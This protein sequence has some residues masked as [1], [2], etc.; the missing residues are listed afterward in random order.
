MRLLRFVLLLSLVS[1][2]ACGGDEAED[3]AG[4]ADAAADSG[5]G[6]VSTDPGADATDD[7]ADLPDTGVDSDAGLPD[8]GED[9]DAGV[10]DTGVDS[11]AGVPDTGVDADAGVPDVGADTDGGGFDAD[12]GNDADTTVPDGGFDADTSVPDGGVDADGGFDADTGVDTGVDTG[13]DTDAGGT[14]D[15]AR[16]CRDLPAAADGVCDVTPGSGA[17]L[18]RGNVLAPD[19][20]LEGG[21]VLLSASGTI[22]CVG[23]DCGAEPEA[24]GATVVTCGDGVIS[25]GLIN[26]H[27]HITF[28][29]NSPGEWGAERF[30]HR[31]DW[32]RGIRGH[33]RVPAAGFAS[34]EEMAWGELRQVM[35][36]TTSLAGSGTGRGFLRNVDG[37][38]SARLGV[39]ADVDYE[40]FPLGDSGGEL[41]SS[42]CGYPELPP[43]SVLGA[44][45][46]LPH[47]SEGIDP[48]ARNEFLCLSSDL[49]GGVDITEPNSAFVHG[50]GLTAID[51]DELALNDT[52][53]IWSPRSNISLYGVTAPVT[54]YA[55]QGVRIG[56]GTDWTPSGSMNMQR[57]LACASYL[58]EV[59]YGGWFSDR[60]LWAMA[61]S[62]NAD[63]LG[64]ADQVGYLRPG[65]FGDIAIYDGAAALSPF[66]AVI[67]ASVADV[68]LVLRAGV[69]MYGDAD[70]TSLFD[71]S[72]AC[73]PMPE[74]VCG[75]SKFV[76]AERESTFDFATLIAENVG[77]YDLFFC[78]EP[79][80]EPT[81]IPSRPGEFA[82]PTA[83][84]MD[85]DGVVDADDLCPMV[86]D[87][88]R[89][90]DD[91]AQADA[92]VDGIG[93]ACDPCPLDADTDECSPP[94][95][96]D[97]DRDGIINADDNCPVVP[98]ED[99]SD[100]DGDLIGDVCDACPDDANPGGS[101][102]PASIY[103]VKT[104]VVAVGSSVAVS[105]VVTAVAD[106]GFFVQVPTEAWDGELAASFSG[107][108][109]YDPSDPDVVLGAP[110]RVTG[111]VNDFFGQIQLSGSLVQP[112]DEDWTLP[113]P[114]P[115]S[116]AD[117]ATDGAV[118]DAYEAVLVSVGEVTVT[119][120][121]LPSGG[122]DS[123]PN[124]EFEVDGSLRVNDFLY[125]IDPAP[126][127]GDV[128]DL[129]GV[130][131]FA[132][133]D[134]KLEPRDGSDV[135]FVGF[136]DPTIV[137]AGPF[138]VYF[139]AGTTGPSVGRTA[140][141]TLLRP[142]PAGLTASV[143]DSEGV[144]VPGTITFEE[145]ELTTDIVL[146]TTAV[147]ATTL[148]TVTVSL[149]GFDSS[150]DVDVLVWDVDG[151]REVVSVSPPELT[152]SFGTSGTIIAYLDGPAGEGVTVAV[153]PDPFEA[154]ASAPTLV[155][156]PVNATSVDIVLVAGET[157]ATAT[158]TV[159][160]EAGSP[161]S[162]TVQ[163]IEEEPART[164]EPGD[165]Y[166]SEI[167]VRSRAGS[168][169]TGEWFEVRNVSAAPLVLDDCEL[170]D[171]GSHAIAASLTVDPG[172]YLVFGASTENGLA[173]DY[174]YD[175][176][177]L[178]NG[179]ETLGI[180]CGGVVIDDFDYPGSLVTLGAS[181]Q[182]VAD[183]LTPET[184][185]DNDNWCVAP[186]D[187]TYGGTALRGTPG[188]ENRCE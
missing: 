49:S 43:L 163:I 98:N 55:S 83:D 177:A 18:L 169:D 105:G 164:P 77:S 122:G 166:V 8:T 140:T 22:V 136:A 168:G 91:G 36:G 111:T 52:S 48:E 154:F 107:I 178:N 29:Q 73:E 138:G 120:D 141:V 87:P 151:P 81:C 152:L 125:A 25:P 134:S 86:F 10:P 71:V 1:L 95:P 170:F 79:A 5:A 26:A 186:A 108:Y 106:V 23:C 180:S 137:D 46:Y 117:V 96:L 68:A 30:D 20:I 184:A 4:S 34:S 165:L 32:R 76:C 84:D 63:A 60:D 187:A 124:N 89:P 179:G 58:N 126:A 38:D 160:G 176:L 153:S 182:L 33:S 146:T 97:R 93:D 113:E 142:A 158:V 88:V 102:C 131:R 147:G 37:S 13:G 80:N 17:L 51:G 61:T 54:M 69:P 112:L 19:E 155:D 56:I 75:V 14:I 2:V 85:G 74:P 135:T 156:V 128:L 41:I 57:E 172:D 162:A 123:D 157:A 66:R 130:L 35:V 39:S 92:D 47:V 174:V 110:V 99:Q 15:G 127:P 173:P 144:V 133:G 161:A 171:N 159:T 82:G 50:I 40:T 175:T 9:T 12:T 78:G 188:A 64:V 145:G 149:D 7:D 104:G 116:A 45:C 70:L 115:V 3:P 100:R 6:D 114:T 16:F 21:E 27:D 167:M 67:D 90:I 62:S 103:D 185:D 139:A 28:T 150:V 121:M 31:H 11:D 143:S 53:V 44:D 59:H 119:N 109:I 183:P 101:A 132:N 118:A 148:T 129:S 181:M 94:D 72:T 42:G 65:L 24:A